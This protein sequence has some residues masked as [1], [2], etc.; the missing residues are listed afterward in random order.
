MIGRGI[1]RLGIGGKEWSNKKRDIF[2]RKHPE[3]LVDQ[4]LYA[5]VKRLGKDTGY[6]LA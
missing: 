2:Q 3:R 6:E 5:L 4:T 1:N